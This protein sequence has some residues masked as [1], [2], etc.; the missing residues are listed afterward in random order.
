MIVRTGVLDGGYEDPILPNLVL[1]GVVTAKLQRRTPTPLSPSI[2]GRGDA[3]LRLKL[4]DNIPME[5]GARASKQCHD[6]SRHR[7]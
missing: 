3:R 2:D 4:S 5:R 1:D 6:P 7:Q